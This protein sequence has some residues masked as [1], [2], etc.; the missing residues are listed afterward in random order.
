MTA[1]IDFVA[2]SIDSSERL[3]SQLSPDVLALKGMSSPKVR[4]LL[5][6]L[7]AHPN[8][9]YLEVGVWAGST[10]ISALYGNAR[11]II[12]ADAI[13]NF[14][15]FDGSRETFEANCRAHLGDRR[16]NLHI[17]SF[18]EVTPTL[19]PPINVYFYDG[20]HSALDQRDALLHFWPCL[21]DE[22]VFVVDDWNCPD[23]KLGTQDGIAKSE[24][25]VTKYW[26]LPAA[27]NG[28]TQQ[29]WNGLFVAVIHK[30]DCSDNKPT[31]SVPTSA[32][33]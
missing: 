13:D 6:N 31:K 4:H 3:L 1:L 25:E 20:N 24:C 9:R 26:E 5:N 30:L 15:Q 32:I 17:H 33:D 29:W 18:R 21:A 27:F 12:G 14:S 7:G 22:F 8:T 11:T 23:A 2:S 28:D 10:F 19:Q 16:F